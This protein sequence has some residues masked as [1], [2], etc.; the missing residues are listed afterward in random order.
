MKRERQFLMT[1]LHTAGNGVLYGYYL[2]PVRLALRARAGLF[3]ALEGNHA[4]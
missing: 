1:G 2:H 4:S 3:F